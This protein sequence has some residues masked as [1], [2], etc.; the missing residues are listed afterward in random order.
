MIIYQGDLSVDR[1]SGNIDKM[2]G[3]VD[4]CIQ[5][6]P[7]PGLMV[8]VAVREAEIR[9]ELAGEVRV[10]VKSDVARGALREVGV[11]ETGKVWQLDSGIPAGISTHV[12]VLQ[13]CMDACP[14]D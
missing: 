8:A 3:I 12:E 1:P 9:I 5:I 6:L 10:L 4:G 2:P 14:V 7:E 11:A 13:L